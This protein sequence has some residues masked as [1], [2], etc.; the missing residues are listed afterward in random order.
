MNREKDENNKYHTYPSMVKATK[1]V[2]D[3]S[4]FQFNPH[5]NLYQSEQ[6]V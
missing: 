6:A 4:V 5:S 3:T 1:C 2:S